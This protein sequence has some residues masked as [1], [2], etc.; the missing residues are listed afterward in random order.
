MEPENVVKV[1]EAQAEE[2]EIVEA[3]EAEM[4]EAPASEPALVKA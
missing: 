3:S 4:I 2:P 1:V